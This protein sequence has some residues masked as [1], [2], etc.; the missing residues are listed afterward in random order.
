MLER[1]FA[2][3]TVVM[4][5]HRRETAM[6][7]ERVVVV[8]QGRVLVPG[9][10]VQRERVRTGACG[11]YGVAGCFCRWRGVLV[12]MGH[13]L[14]PVCFYT[15]GLSEERR[16][17]LSSTHTQNTNTHYDFTRCGIQGRTQKSVP[18]RMWPR[19]AASLGS[20]RLGEGNP[21]HLHAETPS[22]GRRRNKT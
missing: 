17:N 12:A 7:C 14:S 1:E 16:C 19:D 10:V 4:V 3:W 9:V 11:V 22:S 21:G 18:S 5:T 15:E 20:A 8:D 13:Q 6:G 2:A